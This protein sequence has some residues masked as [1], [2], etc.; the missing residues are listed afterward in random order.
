MV[1]HGTAFFVGL[2][3]GEDAAQ[4]RAIIYLTHIGLTP[5]SGFYA[6]FQ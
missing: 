3:L 6:R 1:P 5:R 2:V 4:I